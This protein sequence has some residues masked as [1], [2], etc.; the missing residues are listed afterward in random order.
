M[1]SLLAELK[2]MPYEKY[3]RHLDSSTTSFSSF[4]ASDKG[5]TLF[6]CPVSNF[7]QEQLVGVKSIKIDVTYM[8]VFI[9]Q[10]DSDYPGVLG[11]TMYG[12]TL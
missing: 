6:L 8:M 1:N 3:S 5:K 11:L 4:A 10:L 12:L 9:M 7:Y 2:K